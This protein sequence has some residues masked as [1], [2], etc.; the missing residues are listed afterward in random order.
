MLKG[1]FMAQVEVHQF[2]L[3][4]LAVEEVLTGLRIVDSLGVIVQRIHG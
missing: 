1:K 4:W 3:V 2:S